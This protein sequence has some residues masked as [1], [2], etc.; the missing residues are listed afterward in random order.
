M[1][2]ACTDVLKVTED[3]RELL[4][5]CGEKEDPLVLESTGTALDVIVS[6]R[7]KKVF[8]K[9]GVLFQYKAL[10][11]PPLTPPKDGYEVDRNI[12]DAH[13]MCCV[14]FVFPDTMRRER[15]LHCENQNTWS[16]DLPDCINII[17]PTLIICILLTGNG[18]IIFVIF[19]LRK[20]SLQEC[21]CVFKS[22]LITISWIDHIN[23]E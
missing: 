17:L 9:R 7:S 23:G 12:S 19:Y 1:E 8:P 22:R 11:C 5:M 14:G 18:V 6:I 3:D 13:Y 20:S 21:S 15:S 4:S 2:S 16:M 10:G